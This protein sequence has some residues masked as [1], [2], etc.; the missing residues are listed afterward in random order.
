MRNRSSDETVLYVVGQCATP[1]FWFVPDSLKGHWYICSS[2]DT[3][4]IVTS[5]EWPKV[6]NVLDFDTAT[7]FFSFNYWAELIQ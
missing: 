1:V 7:V 3:V 5:Q 4:V 6:K 2:G